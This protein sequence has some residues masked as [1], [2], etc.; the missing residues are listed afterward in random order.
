[1]TEEKIIILS[2][3]DLLQYRKDLPL[4]IIDENDIRR[5]SMSL[6]SYEKAG[7]VVFID[8]DGARKVLKN[9]NGIE[10]VEK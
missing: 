7:K 3:E 6:E 10:G 1:M 9:R 2:R 8:N 4:E 5:T